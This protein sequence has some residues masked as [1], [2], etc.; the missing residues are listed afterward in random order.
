MPY[1]RHN[2]D[3]SPESGTV[4]TS[5][6]EARQG[7][8][9]KV[10]AVSFIPSDEESDNWRS[11]ERQRFLDNVYQPLPWIPSNDLPW[12][13]SFHTEETIWHYAHL[14]TKSPG[15]I[16]YTASEEHGHLDRQTRVKPGRYLKEFFSEQLS[17]AQIAAYAVMCDVDS[18]SLKFARTKEDITRVY[19]CPTTGWSSCMQWKKDPEYSW[20]RFYDQ[21]HRPHPC[22]VYAD[23][24]LAVAYLGNLDAIIAR[25]VVWPDE[26]V[27]KQLYGDTDRLRAALTKVGY[28][29][30]DLDGA[31]IRRVSVDGAV[32]MPYID[33]ISHARDVGDGWLLLGSGAIDCQI[34]T[35]VLEQVDDDDDEIEEFQCQRCESMIHIH[36][37][38]GDY[39]QSCL[40]EQ[41]TCE[42]CD[43]CDWEERTDTDDHHS[44][45][46]QC[47]DRHVSTCS[48]MK[49]NHHG[50]VLCGHTWIE[51]FLRYKTQCERNL[52]NITHLCLKCAEGLQQCQH[53][54]TDENNNGILFDSLEPVC[55]SCNRAVRCE[56]TP[57]LLEAIS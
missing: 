34:T 22:V 20:Q 9:F 5:A 32:M 29:R 48:Q 12:F 37:G 30:G 27:Y 21:G 47:Y 40:D 51:E 52:L 33:G 16:A 31:R 55:P 17:P 10:L 44:L 49:T 54:P 35:G 45:C 15:M 8:D 39:C 4:F 43:T 24:D 57:D 11:R 28:S 6:E 14:S 23:S 1:Y 18:L 19:T 36:D 2:R 7:V 13:S 56:K 25:A 46:N 26:K 3:D 50:S 38:D 41:I 42:Y 53:C